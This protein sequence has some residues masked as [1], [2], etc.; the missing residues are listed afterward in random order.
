MLTFIALAILVYTYAGY[1]AVAWFMARRQPAQTDL[2]EVTPHVA[3]IVAAYNEGSVALDKL[4]NTRALDYPSEK[5]SIIF[6]TDGSTD[7]S[8]ERLMAAGATVLHQPAR[9]GKSAALNRAAAYVKRRVGAEVL[10]FTDANAMLEPHALR[11]LVAPYADPNVGGV[12]GEKRVQA[13]T[14]AGG[15]ASE[16]AYWRY[17]SALKRLDAR[18]HSVVGAAGELF[19]V[20]TDLFEPV[21][22]DTVLDDFMLSLRVAEQGYRVAYAPEA[23]A[24]EAPSASVADEWGRKVRI[25]A[26]GFQAMRRLPGL[27]KIRTHGVLTVQYVSHR[28]LRWTLAPLALPVALGSSIA[29]AGSSPVHAALAVLQLAAYALAG[30]GYLVRHRP[31]APWWLRVPFYFVMMNAAVYAGFFRHLRGRQ[32]AAWARVQRRSDVAGVAGL[33]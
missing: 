27:W 6:V 1:A 4:A 11:R 18:W 22:A 15:E 16:G 31:N 8:P 10:V 29:L 5:L 24:L 9:Q 12:A 7:D 30:A 33:V 13:S 19:S 23:Q 20:R 17:E 32:P 21:P 14:D 25:C 26:G 28:V 3:F 2:P